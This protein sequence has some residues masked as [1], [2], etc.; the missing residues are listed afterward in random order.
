MRKSTKILILLLLA[1]S[2]HATAQRSLSYSIDQMSDNRF[3]AICEDSMGFIWIGTENGL[4]RFDG[5][6]FYHFF[7]DDSDS[8]SL[9]SNYVKSLFLDN[10]GRLWVGTGRG[11]QYMNP[12]EKTFHTVKLS[13]NVM[14]YVYQLSQ[15]SD[16]KIWVVTSGYGIH[17]IDPASPDTGENMTAINSQ[18]GVNGMF[19]AILEDRSGII[20]LGTPL[21]VIRYEPST[22][23]QSW[24]MPDI[25][26]RDITG[27]HMDTKGDIYI[28]TNRHLYK[29]HSK[30]GDL[31]SITPPE[32]LWEIT[33]SFMDG[34]DNLSLSIR[35]KGLIVLNHSTNEL[36]RPDAGSIERIL[37]NLD[38]SVMYNDKVGNKWVGCFLSQLMLF[39]ENDSRNS[40]S[41]RQFSD[42]REPISGS[43]TALTVDHNGNLW[44]GYN[45]NTLTKMAPDGKIILKGSPNSLANSLFSD[46][47]NRIWVGLFYGGLSLLRQRSGHLENVVRN[48]IAS[49]SSIAEDLQGRIYF[50][51]LGDGFSCLD[52]TDM[53]VTHYTAIAKHIEGQWLSNV[54]IY[55]MTVD[56][57]NRLWIGHENGIDCF[58]IERGV[59]IKLNDIK[60][61]IGTSKSCRTILADSNGLI[62]FGTNRGLFM[63]DIDRA[64]VQEFTVEND[65]TGDDIRGIVEDNSGNIWVST[66]MGF[67]RIDPGTYTVN[68]FFSDEKAYNNVSAFDSRTGAVYFASNYGIT[69]FDPEHI[70]SGSTLNKVL[71]TG[72]YLKDRRMTF[73]MT[74]GGKH[75]SDKPFIMTDR[76]N[77]AYKDNSFTM[78]FSTLNF[79]YENNIIYEYTLDNKNREDWSSTP[80]GVNRI[81]FYKLG[82]GNNHLTVR[83]R[84]NDSVS[85]PHTFL[86]K[87]A[88]PWYASMLAYVIYIIMIITIA[89]VVIYVLKNKREK[90]VNATRLD[91]FIN[92]AHEICT[93]M[94]MVISPLEEMLG[95]DNVPNEKM[96]QLRQM[97]KNSVRILSLINQL[98]DIRKYDEGSMELRFVE[99]DI[100]NFLMGPIELYMQTAEHRAI[101]FNFRH[102][103][104]ELPVWIDRDSID[105]V[106]INLLSNAFKYTP[107]EGAIE[108]SVDVGID[109]SEVGPLHNY[110]KISVSDTGKGLDD[111]D[112]DRLFD[113]FYR[114]HNDTTTKT[115]GMGIGLNYSSILVKMHHGD[116]KAENRTDG[117]QGSIFSFRLPLG[118]SHLKPEEIV[119]SEEV[120]RTH[121]ER[122]RSGIELPELDFKRSSGS[123]IKVLVVDDDDAMLNYI[124]ESLMHSYRVY[125]CRNGSEALKMTLS[126]KP[127][128]IVSDVVMPEMDGIQLVKALKGNS[129][130]SHIPII[131]LSG[132]SKLQDRVLGME[133]GADYYLPKPF[134]MREL[135]TIINNLITNR[136]IVKGKFSGKQ[137]QK[138]KVTPVEFISSD[139]QFMKRVMEVVNKNLS[140]S[141]FD[142][143][144]MAR[145]IGI[146]RTHL[147]RKLKELTGFPS[148]KFVQNIRM[149]QAMKLLKEKKNNVSQIAYSVGFSS[150]THFSTTFKQYYG[151]SPTEF[152]K[153]I[154]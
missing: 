40:L 95:D 133:I 150:Q 96:L 43:V 39:T 60:K 145:E 61:V 109:D 1:F 79:G 116:I 122:E 98:L 78:E 105:K 115:I 58:D 3:H 154:D 83:A 41:Y 35:G 66:K 32:E 127:D 130:V 47:K 108:V 26:N 136:L 147:H 62:W 132:K 97:H 137:E 92:V 120:T 9:C 45:N 53:S 90:E 72:L 55:S 143:E 102:A 104:V 67:N 33:H 144:Q 118:N 146:S 119:S 100:I 138:D 149:Q 129:L 48:E 69:T 87:I 15:L 30:T 123:S 37:D 81:N 74:S 31:E 112:T 110:V 52:P 86:I 22:E 148:A 101:A 82:Y 93:P 14:P 124:K 27:L 44:I 56:T 25:I 10:D 125:T 42:Y 107:N 153:Q 64:F 111:V 38:V 34:S 151:V 73:D 21:G 20:W 17:R 23:Q 12:G 50:S 75:I 68:R 85:E 99:T 13:D 91:S 80:A 24:F 11:V 88:P 36:Q 113:R 139:E 128:I 6:R 29:F 57:H 8:L 54:W 126:H 134:Y 135:K 77:L 7:H 121:L 16:G 5:Y 94:T 18:A 89:T 2:I 28:T 140:N 70:S 76:L 51:E 117:S 19:R 4:N 49:I 142:V 114:A 59:F 71:I 131:L 84:L 63:Y 103:I 152:I 46:S 141:E 65:M 106:M